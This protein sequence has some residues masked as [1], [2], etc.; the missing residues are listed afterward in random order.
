MFEV[1]RSTKAFDHC[2]VRAV[3]NIDDHSGRTAMICA[4]YPK[5]FDAGLGDIEYKH[6][7]ASL[8]LRLGCLACPYKKVDLPAGEDA[9]EA[10]VNI[11]QC[12]TIEEMNRL[13]LDQDSEP[14][15]DPSDKQ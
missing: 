5:G 6:N 11:S 2:S 9:R 14:P 15:F 8:A 12:N 1:Q 7:R 13:I 10:I 3:V 4:K